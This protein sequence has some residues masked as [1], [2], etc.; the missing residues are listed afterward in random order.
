MQCIGGLES[1]GRKRRSLR[2]KISK[3]ANSSSANLELAT[4][5]SSNATSNLFRLIYLKIMFIRFKSRLTS[6]YKYI[7]HD[8]VLL[9]ELGSNNTIKDYSG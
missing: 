5:D 7:F 8:R 9:R 6:Y 4:N 1:Y 2:H 3:M